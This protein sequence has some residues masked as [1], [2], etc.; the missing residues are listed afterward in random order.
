MF[1]AG[2]RAELLKD[3]LE[4]MSVLVDEAVMQVADDGI[5]S[6]AVEPANAAM[7]V[8]DMGVKAFESFEADG[9]ELGVDL[10]R[11]SKALNM[12]QKGDIA[13]LELE[14]DTHKLRLELSGITYHL[15]LLDPSTIRRVPKVPQLELPARILMRGVDLQRAIRAASDVGSYLVLGVEDDSFYVEVEGD[16]DKMRFTLTRDE[17]IDLKGSNARSLFSLEYLRDI[18]KSRALAGSDILLEIGI[19]YPSRLSFEFADGTCK[20]TYIVAPRVESA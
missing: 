4:V 13:M 9:G 1:K 19:D 3:A 8:L 7:V 2:I 5:H 20:G 16:T 14:E 12:A 15:S 17:L 18:S 11:L 6:K 10:T